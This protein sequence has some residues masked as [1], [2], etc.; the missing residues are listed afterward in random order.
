MGYVPLDT[1][2]NPATGLVAPAAWGD[3]VHANLEA[4]VDPPV[5]SV[6][7]SVAV[8]VATGVTTF[9]AADSENDDTDGMHTTGGSNSRITA[10]T[11]GRFLCIATVLFA[12]GAV[13]QRQLLFRQDG[14]TSFGGINVNAT[15]A[16][17]MRLC[18]PM[19]RPLTVGQY[20]EVGVLHSQGANLNVTLEEFAL[21]W[22]ARL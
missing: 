18:A 8:A 4:L 2:H 1:I 7:H 12:A 16:G 11:E 5:C 3:Q 14:T 9:L 15:G 17:S 22:Q 10:Q 20:V 21:L 6:F 19:T 13:G